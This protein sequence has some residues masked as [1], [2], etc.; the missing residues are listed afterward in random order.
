MY[1]GKFDQKNKQASTDF[2]ELLS[3]RNSA[4]TEK[5]APGKAVPPMEAPVKKEPTV[6]GAAPKAPGKEAAKAPARDTT[7]KASAKAPA[8]RQPQPAKRPT[9]QSAAP[10]KRGP[11]LGGVIF[12]TLYFMF[13]LVFF[14]ATFVGLL[15]LRGWLEDYELAQPTAKAEQVFTQLFTDPDWDALYDASGVQDTAF[16]GKEEFVAY[17]NE[18]IGSSQLAYLETSAGLSG[19]KKYLVRL[20]SEKVAS[21]T[22]VDKN[23]VGDT[24]LDNLN[25]LPDWQLGAVE[26]FFSRDCS[27]QIVKM[28]GHTAYVNDVPL[29]DD[30]TI[31]IATTIAENYLPE[32]TTGVSMCTQ[33]VSGLV[34]LPVVTVFDDKGNQME[35]TYDEA[36]RTFTERTESNTITPEEQEAVLNAARTECKWMIK[37]VTDRGTV[38]KYFDSSCTP[39]SNIVKTTELWMQSH[40]GYEFVDESVT[41]YC[42]YTDELFSVRVSL[43]L[44][45][46]RTDGTVKE[47]PYAKSMFFHKNDSG[48]WV[49]FE[50]TNVDITKPVGK[51]RLTFMSG[52]TELTSNF[53]QTDAS[54]IITPLTTIPEGKVFSGWATLSEDETGNTVYN[55]VFQ[56][57]ETGRVS[58]P[59]GTTL[60]PMTLYAVFENAGTAST[61]VPET[62]EGE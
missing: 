23:N 9:V 56:P 40:M 4:A 45:V 13:I 3:Q 11:R 16:E 57:D 49:C 33:E 12:Y 55:L 26:V 50:E 30:Y 20:G 29:D 25:K 54:E 24:T 18:K 51:V 61:T 21:F 19:G 2:Q 22:L 7:A 6:R 60:E 15:W 62:T 41:D 32:G 37:E 44:N 35:V 42:R 17:M 28:N 52:D 46:T 59:E 47:Y 53:F 48:R 43:T 31:Q 27:Y 5:T 34:T 38:A 39:Y 1:K 36:A 14:V 58:I 8:A 10:Q